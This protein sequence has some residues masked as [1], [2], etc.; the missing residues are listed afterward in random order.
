M[1]RRLPFCPPADRPAALASF[2]PRVVADLA[3]G[4]PV[5]AGILRAGG[6]PTLPGDEALSYMVTTKAD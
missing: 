4:D 2:A 3:G 6:Q 5:A 1:D